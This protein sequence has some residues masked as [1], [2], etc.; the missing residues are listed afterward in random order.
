MRAGDFH[1]VGAMFRQC[2]G[3]GRTGEN[4][5]QVEHAYA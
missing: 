5:R 1:D 4:A 2:A 3:A